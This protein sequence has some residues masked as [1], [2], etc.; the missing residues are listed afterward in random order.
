MELAQAGLD[1]VDILEDL[2]G[3]G[4][5][6]ALVLHRQSGCV[7]LVEGDVGPPLGAVRGHGKHLRAGVDAD[8]RAFVAHL[9]EQL[10]HEEAWPTADVE[11]ALAPRSPERL[12]HEAPA[13]QDVARPVDHLH[14]L[15][16]PLVE[17]EHHLR[18]LAKQYT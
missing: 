15:R 13:P 5:V 4:A 17:F 11:D 7:P 10:S 14:L 18:M 12:V 8:D 6:E 2:H 16:E 9:I 1:V 3:E